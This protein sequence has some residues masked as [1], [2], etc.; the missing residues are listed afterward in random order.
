MVRSKLDGPN[1]TLKDTLTCGPVC[2]TSPS[3]PPSF[4][5]P[6]QAQC[7]RHFCQLGASQN[8]SKHESIPLILRAFKSPCQF[9]SITTSTLCYL[10]FNSLKPPAMP[11]GQLEPYGDL[12]LPGHYKSVPQ[13]RLE[14]VVPTP[15]LPSLQILSSAQILKF[16]VGHRSSVF[17]LLWRC[18]ALSDNFNHLYGIASTSPTSCVHPLRQR[19]SGTLSPLLT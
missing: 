10:P 12:D 2:A 17:R 11:R 13:E 5:I 1:A 3:S 18:E 14:A 6:V 9:A 8:P 16:F 15:Q 7:V 4:F 19:T